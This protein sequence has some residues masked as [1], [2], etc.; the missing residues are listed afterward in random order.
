MKKIYLL[1]LQKKI[2][3]CILIRLLAI[4]SGVI[5]VY[6]LTIK[7]SGKKIAP[8]GFIEDYGYSCKLNDVVGVLLE[9]K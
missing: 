5:Y 3:I 4:C 8:D 2:L 1:E 9:F 6:G 7:N